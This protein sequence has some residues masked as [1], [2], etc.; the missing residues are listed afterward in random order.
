MPLILPGNVASATA[1]VTYNVANSC[2]FNDGDSPMM[3]LTPGSSATDSKKMTISFWCKL[4][5]LGTNR[6][7]F[8][9]SNAGDDG[10]DSLFFSDEDKLYLFLD[11]G[12]PGNLRTNRLFRDPSAWYHIVVAIDTTQSTDTNRVKFY[13]NGI[14]E[15]SF[16]TGGDGII[17]PDQNY[18]IVGYGQNGR[19]ATIGADT[20]GGGNDNEFDGYLAEFVFIDGLQLAPTSFGEFNEDSPTIW[21]PIDVSGL[22]FGSPQ[23]GRA[24]V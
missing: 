17:W 5:A 11:N 13:V 6:R 1:D 3:Q 24:H 21:Q 8:S 4:G 23:I 10:R 2:R 12:N 18:D 9:A 20:D 15:T 19:E 16:D 22:T 14:Q 7:V